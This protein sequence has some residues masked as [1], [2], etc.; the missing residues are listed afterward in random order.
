LKRERD[1]LNDFSKVSPIN[2]PHFEFFGEK[3]IGYKKISGQK[4]TP[5]F[6]KNLDLLEQKKVILQ[7]G[8]FLKVLHSLQYQTQ[9][10][11]G[12]RNF[13]D[14]EEVAQLVIKIREIIFPKIL[15]Y[16]QDN[17]NSF[18]QKFQK[19]E[20]N[21]QNLQGCV[22]ADLFFNNILWDHQ[23]STLGVIDF[24]D[25]EK[26]V[27]VKDFTLLADFCD[28]ENDLFLKNLIEVYGVKDNDLFR[29]VKEFSRLEKLYW[30][31]EDREDSI[32]DPTRKNDFDENLKKMIE[33][34]KNERYI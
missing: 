28:N 25:I 20:R 17:I 1:F 9:V 2:V 21:F 13:F 23:E 34:F 14:E 16:I 29:K 22:H 6:F 26:D 3:I 11:S 4:I 5:N 15:G 7:I 8:N 24:G 30:P 19:D 12:Y 33:V 18:L 27:I 32:I 31:V 10:S